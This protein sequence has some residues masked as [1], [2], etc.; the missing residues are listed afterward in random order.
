MKHIFDAIIILGAGLNVPPVVQDRIVYA[1]KL[2]HKGVAPAVILCGG[3]SAKNKGIVETEA[4][5][6]QRF[7]IMHGIHPSDMYLEQHSRD[8]IGAAYFCKTKILEPHGWTN[9]II[10]TTDYH[11]DRTLYTFHKVLGPSFSCAVDPAKGRKSF[12][13]FDDRKTFRA[14]KL[15]F[16]LLGNGKTERIRRFLYW[17]HPLY[18]TAFPRLGTFVL[19]RLGRA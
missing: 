19:R 17:F 13:W 6:M 16:V 18:S 12:G 8:T 2:Y 14:T 3:A 11:S 9:V 5:Q 4:K 7:A 15:L 10:V 1:A